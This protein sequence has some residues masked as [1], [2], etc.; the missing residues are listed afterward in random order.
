MACPVVTFK[1]RTLSW[2]THIFLH[3]YSMYGMCVGAAA[4]V[5][6][7]ISQNILKVNIVFD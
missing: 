2:G 7:V 5:A 6:S 1:R 4:N 3:V